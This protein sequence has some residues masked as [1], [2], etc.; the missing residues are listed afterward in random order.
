MFYR[1]DMARQAREAINTVWVLIA[2]NVIVYL[3][4]INPDGP[5]ALWA[6]NY[7]DAYPFRPWQLVTYMFLHADF[8]HLLFNMYGLFLFGRLVAPVLGRT[9]F[10]ILY[11]VGGIVGG[12]LHLAA[13][14]NAVPPNIAV[15][16]SGALFG[17]MMAVAMIRPNLE[18]YIMFIPVPVKM[19]TLVLVY[20]A[21]EI[22][23]QWKLNTHVAHLAHLGGFIGGYLIMLCFFGIVFC[24]CFG[25]LV[26]S[27]VKFAGRSPLRWHT[28]VTAGNCHINCPFQ[29]PAILLQAVPVLPVLQ[30]FH[31]Q[32]VN[33]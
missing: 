4:P 7:K 14:W 30:D 25:I 13:N 9:R 19:K 21:L 22:F 20:A 29:M 18:M 31:F 5:L 16:A 8:M 17:V 28:A 27:S 12:L 26:A 32:P 10:L 11:F 6:N 33:A 2:I 3:L 1:D 23:S 24:L 15:G